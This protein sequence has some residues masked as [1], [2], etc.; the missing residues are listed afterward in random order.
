MVQFVASIKT[1]CSGCP[2][3]SDQS[4]D[5]MRVPLEVAVQASR[6]DVGCSALPPQMLQNP[7]LSARLGHSELSLQVL[8]L[9][10]V[11]N[12]N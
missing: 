4:A 9:Q 10:E 2:S 3:E 7:A 6:I 5:M 1:C 12:V 8:D 11:G